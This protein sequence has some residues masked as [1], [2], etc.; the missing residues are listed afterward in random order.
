MYISSYIFKYINLV[1]TVKLKFL[2]RK[3][4][5]ELKQQR[6]K[7]GNKNEHEKQDIKFFKPLELYFMNYYI[8]DVVLKIPFYNW[9]K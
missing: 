3:V 8:N 2:K 1:I 9:Y 6:N 4:I 7:S 5:R